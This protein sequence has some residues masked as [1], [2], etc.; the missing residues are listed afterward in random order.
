MVVFPPVDPIFD[1]QAAY[2]SENI[3]LKYEQL[4]PLPFSQHP[5]FTAIE[6]DWA[7]QGLVNGGFF[8]GV[9]VARPQ[10][11]AQ[12]EEAPICSL[13]SSLYLQTHVIR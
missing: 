13:D 7:V 12:S 11:F 10:M 6:Q 2:R 5:R 8:S 4:V 3:S 1:F 9:N